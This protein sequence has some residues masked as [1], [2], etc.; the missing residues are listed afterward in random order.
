[1]IGRFIND[2]FIF[3]G[4]DDNVARQ[5]ATDRLGSRRLTCIIGYPGIESINTFKICYVVSPVV[6]H[7]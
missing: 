3:H 5:L 2:L 1:M 4:I 6:F 7:I